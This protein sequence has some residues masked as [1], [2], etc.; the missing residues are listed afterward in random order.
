MLARSDRYRGRRVTL[1]TKH[2]K[3][4]ALG[5]VLSE[6]VGCA[7]EVTSAYDT[8]ELGTFT[9]EIPRIGSQL[10]AAR[11]KAE[12]ALKES[13]ATLGLGSE[14]SFSPGPFGL[15]AWNLELVVLRDEELGVEVVGRAEGPGHQLHTTVR[16]ERELEAF[17]SRAGF[18]AHGLVVRPD[19]EHAPYVAR[20]L[21]DA[22]SLSGAFR[23]ALA[24]SKAGV[25]F[26]ESDLRAYRNPTRMARIAEAGRDLAVRLLCLC[27]AC[28]T[29]GFGVA[30]RLGGLPCADCGAPTGE[31]RA[32]RWACVR[33]DATETRPIA[34]VERAD[35][36][37]CP[38]C[39]P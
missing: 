15:Y 12:L 8:D 19:D 23:A 32:E 34:G 11:K 21:E 36:S 5:P 29:P 10:E 9:R 4:V 14:G 24:C 38:D 26:V 6:R 22:E 30:S 37:S 31:L 7:V 39:N 20:D 18:P 3:E 25:V 17:A 1:L 27:P 2:R 33:C 16:S 35:P 13:G 28:A